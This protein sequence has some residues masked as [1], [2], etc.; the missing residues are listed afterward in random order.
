MLPA[1]GGGPGFN[2]ASPIPEERAGAIN[3]YKKVVDLCAEWGGRTC[4][5]VAGCQVFGT[6]RAEA[7]EWSRSALTEIA[8]AARDRDVTIAVEPTPADSN[9][10]DTIDDALRMM[11]ESGA[12]NVK[13]MFDTFHA[14][15]RSEVPSDY[16]YRA[17]SNLHH[18]HLA[19]VDRRPPGAGRVDYR[20]LIAA[21]KAV[22]YDGYLC[23]EIGFNT[24]AI[25]PDDF[26]QRAYDYIRPLAS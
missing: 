21:L 13:V 7:W 9:L 11:E 2:V 5:Y 18:V 20:A 4:L 3:Q 19:D 25:E 8:A 15:Y 10:V 23:M 16:V 1:P 26:A 22:G 14:L 6:T 24:R 17:G 12:P